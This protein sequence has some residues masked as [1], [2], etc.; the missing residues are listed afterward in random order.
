MSIDERAM[1]PFGAPCSLKSN[2]GPRLA[3]NR[4]GPRGGQRLWP[5]P[6]SRIVWLFPLR[7]TRLAPCLFEVN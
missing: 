6:A 4:R 5:A 2:L 7:T 3:S 1:P